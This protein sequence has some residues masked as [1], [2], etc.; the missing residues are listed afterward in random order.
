MALRFAVTM[1][2]AVATTMV[3]CASGTRVAPASSPTVTAA[4]APDEDEFAAGLMVQ[5]RYHQGGV[6][7]FI[8]LSLD[9]LGVS[10]E[11]RAAVERIRAALGARLEPERLAEQ[12]FL[13]KL[14][15]G[16][17]AGTLDVSKVDAALTQVRLAAATARDAPGDALNELH[18]VL[19]PVQR[20]ALVDKVEAHW[21]LW[22][23]A[24]LDT[25]DP[26]SPS[27]GYLS[28]LASELGLTADQVDKLRAGMG[29]RMN[30][31]PRL[32]TQ[33]AETQLQAFG[34]AFAGESFDAKSFTAAMNLDGSINGWS[35]AHMAH[36][37][38]TAVLVL[39]PEQRTKLA[40]MLREHAA[41]EA[42]VQA[43]P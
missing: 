13:A 14:A 36:F 1:A 8:A 21:R 28:I 34:E 3:A 38:E 39:S 2:V 5:H 29:E 40:E 41:H 32:D 4:S 10:P 26:A 43:N 23:Q 27:G 9:T 35:A 7:R 12:I 20:Q 37:V 30:G 24:S 11:Q 22:R 15:D 31:V 19:T 16:L 6:T 25:S 17:A 42:T 33:A 18:A